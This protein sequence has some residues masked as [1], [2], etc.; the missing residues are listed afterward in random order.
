MMLE[1]AVVY[2]IDADQG[3]KVGI[4]CD[5]AGR[6]RELERG[7]GH[8]NLQIV[9]SYPMDSRAHAYRVEQDAHWLLHDTRTVGEWFHCHPF[10]ATAAVE[11]AVRRAP[12]G[13]S[14]A[15]LSLIAQ[16]KQGQAA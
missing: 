6:I 8:R 7:S 14:V 1:G 13:A 5:L 4:S 15:P 10:D 11:Y 9:R 16:I 3:V 12:S 2:V